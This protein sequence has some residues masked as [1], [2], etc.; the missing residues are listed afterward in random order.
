MSLIS[1]RHQRSPSN[2][3]A[4]ANKA[5]QECESSNLVEGLVDFTTENYNK[6][7]PFESAES[8]YFVVVDEPAVGKDELCTIATDEILLTVSSS[9]C[10]QIPETGVDVNKEEG[11][12]EE[13]FVPENTVHGYNSLLPQN[14]NEDDFKINVVGDSSVLKVECNASFKHGPDVSAIYLFDGADFTSHSEWDNVQ[15]IELI[16]GTDAGD[17]SR[18]VKEPPRSS[19]LIPYEEAI[20][21]LSFSDV[22]SIHRSSIQPTIPLS[23]FS[24]LFRVCFGPPR[25]PKNLEAERDFAFC[26]AQCAFDNSDEIHVRILQTIYKRL[27]GTRFDCPR[28]GSHWEQIGFQGNDPVTDLRGAGLLGLYQLLYLVM[29]V[30]T[31]DLCKKLYRLSLD[32]TQNFPLC[33]IGINLTRVT[34]ATLREGHLNKECKRRNEVLGVINRFF[35]GAFHRFY[36]VWRTEVKTIADAGFVLNDLE[37]YVKKHPSETVETITKLIKPTAN[38]RGREI[39]ESELTSV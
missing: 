3:F 29:D 20:E 24:S 28:F 23:G 18:Q 32:E 37:S 1:T 31:E 21:H 6:N 2:R 26:I 36:S 33:L 38:E 25:L 9:V 17:I 30:N 16:S 19:P 10:A 13:N 39:G 7:N 27:T 8:K 12:N 34:L 14:S 15:T 35:A 4:S 5:D 11:V 22:L